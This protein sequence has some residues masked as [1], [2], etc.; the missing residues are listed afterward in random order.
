MDTASTPQPKIRLWHPTFPDVTQEVTQE[1]QSAWTEQGWKTE[2]PHEAAQ[3]APTQPDQS[4]RRAA[5]ETTP[6]EG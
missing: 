5:I 2:N 1:D 3:E 6:K 4:R